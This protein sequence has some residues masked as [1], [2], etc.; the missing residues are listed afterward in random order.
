MIPHFDLIKV[1]D[2]ILVQIFLLCLQRFQIPHK[3]FSVTV[4]RVVASDDARA[5]IFHQRPDEEAIFRI[6]FITGDEFVLG[7]SISREFVSE[8]ASNYFFLLIAST[9]TSNIYL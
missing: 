7:F 2:E 3:V 9:R 6:T 5:P 8:L 4:I 1:S